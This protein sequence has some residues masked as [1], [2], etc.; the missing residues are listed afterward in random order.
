MQGMLMASGND[1]AYALAR[2]N[3]NMA[4]TLQERNTT[5]ADL[6]ACGYRGQRPQRPG[7]DR[8]EK[9]RL[10]PGLDR[11]Y[12]DEARDLRGYVKTKQTCIP[13]G[14]V[15]CG[16]LDPG[17]PIANHNQ[18]LFGCRG[19]IG[20]KNGYPSA[21]KFTYV[22]AAARGD[23]TYLLTEMA[24]PQGS[25]QPAAA[26][27]DWVF[28]QGPS[29]T[30]IGA[31]VESGTSATSKPPAPAPTIATGG[32]PRSASATSP[33]ES[34]GPPPLTAR[35]GVAAGMSALDLAGTWAWRTISG[36]RR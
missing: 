28:A 3:Q 30:P 34:A 2:A 6:G 14:R 22:Q 36:R 21:A 24:S 35:I 23:K 16:K 29:L 27:L 12:R 17:F 5:A 11:S 8:S 20:I 25:W 31:L 18:Q 33:P 19:A 9:Q 10:R 13:G 4:V 1:A 26:M 32:H 15:A 7:E